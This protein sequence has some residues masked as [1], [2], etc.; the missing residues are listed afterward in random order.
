MSAWLASHD[1]H[2]AA[3][4]LGAWLALLVM[5]AP[6]VRA[7][8][9]DTPRWLLVSLT[10]LA[11]A[12]FAVSGW[13]IAAFDR[14]VPLGHEA[15]YAS[16]FAGHV[17]PANAHGWEP[18]VTYPILRWGY[19][20][21]G[22]IVGRE[23]IE[24]VL[25][26]NLAAR[27]VTVVVVGLASAALFRR[28]EAGVLA[29]ALLALHPAHALWGAAIYNVAIPLLFAA[30]CVWLAVLAWRDGSPWM[31]A[32]AAASGC[33][34]VATRI[35]WGV[36]APC[37]A[38]LLFGG[39]SSDWGRS[40]A[41]RTVRFWA[42]AAGVVLL[43]GGA[44]LLG[45]GSLTNQGGYHDPLGY[46]ETLGRQVWI[47]D[48]LE[49]LQRPWTLALCA[50]GAVWTLRRVHGCIRLLSGLF[51]AAVL[52][53][54][55]MATF[56]DFAFRHEL[57]AVLFLCLLGGAAGP[58]VV[59]AWRAGGSQRGLAAGTA[60][61]LVATVG[62][63]LAA[64]A[65]TAD[66]YYMN[67]EAFFA[68][69]PGFQSAEIPHTSL[70]DGRCYLITDNERLWERGLAGSHFNLMEPGEAALHWQ[71]HGGCIR[72]LLDDGDHRADGL[73]VRPRAIKLARWFD[74]TLI[75]Y[76]RFPDGNDAVVY[77]MASPPWGLTAPPPG[78]RW[79]V[80]S[81]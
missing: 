75:G 10:F 70:E 30:V 2:V 55:A 48:F 43:L 62:S 66:R 33:L 22:G 27:S 46:L 68:A 65:D 35:E 81:E 16:C 32:A 39:L 61:L 40:P 23:T 78:W 1:G 80:E 53:H 31:L 12:A 51:G 69:H 14:F 11:L 15:S 49:P 67:E 60:A 19:W 52:A 36:L 9:A 76:A 21:L 54:G 44:T 4:Q 17:T 7:A 29:A 73:A 77:E 47:L 57:L 24:A 59:D 58:A 64:L 6:H 25:A 13:W 79:E 5:A 8:L 72:W 3:A 56:N 28:P 42:P 63:A 18:F 37:L 34:V 50:V 74:W 26:L 41:V 71:E 20:A 38:L 45:P